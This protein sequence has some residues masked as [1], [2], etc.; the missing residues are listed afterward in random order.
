ME[1]KGGSG[2][3]GRFAEI[4][5]RLQTGA[6]NAKTRK[7][8]RNYLATYLKGRAA[9]GSE[10]VE[11]RKAQAVALMEEINAYKSPKAPKKTQKRVRLPPPPPRPPSP[12]PAKEDLY[13]Q[14]DVKGDGNCYYR[15]LYRAA[16]AHEDKTI[17][18][19][20]FTVLG[21][22]KSKMS[23]EETGH[24]ALR[25]AIADYYR[26]KFLSRDGPYEM[27]L[28][29]YGTMQF[30]LWT[31]EATAG[32]AA[33]YRNIKK[34]AARKD[35]KAAF[36]KDLADVIG[37]DKEY[38]SDIDYMIIS[39]ILD[40]GGI[41][42]VS[43]AASPKT[44][45]FDGKP[46]LYIKRLSYDHYNFWRRKPAAAAPKPAAAAAPKP[47]AAAAA[48]APKSAA[49]AP[50][51]AAPVNTDP[52]PAGSSSSGESSNNDEEEDKRTELL[53]ELDRRMEKHA[54][55]V[56]K[57]RNYSRKVDKARTELMALGK[58]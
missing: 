38:A 8:N 35:G 43:A 42:V 54:R 7:V 21:A 25:K 58:K 53:A 37:T 57:C 46:A 33:V 5:G 45:I 56:E 24:A 19:R 6:Y 1:E 3:K 31:H 15:A 12:K 44:G 20:M 40:V 9:A 30:R 36:Y 2:P 51:P 52:S 39:D 13:E 55:C 32:Q 28:A 22:D 50:K 48:A 17:L 29:N 23:K 27:L 4:T 16:A 11:M 41:K 18:D 47:A 10:A 34:Y 26:T 14:V 49:A